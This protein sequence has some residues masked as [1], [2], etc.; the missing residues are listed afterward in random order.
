MGSMDDKTGDELAALRGRLADLE[1][2]VEALSIG[3]NE[4]A[5]MMT[6][7]TQVHLAR[8]VTLEQTTAELAKRLGKE[9]RHPDKATTAEEIRQMVRGVVLAHLYAPRPQGWTQD[10]AADA[11]ADDVAARL[12]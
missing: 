11:I 6:A 9:D 8:I 2:R 4:Y 10:Q 12:A 5:Q 3:A 1:Q 7:R